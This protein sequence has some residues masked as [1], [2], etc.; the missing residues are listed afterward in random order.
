MGQPQAHRQSAHRRHRSDR[1]AGA[2]AD[3]QRARTAGRA[4]PRCACTPEP[5]PLFRRRDAAAR[6]RAPHRPGRARRDARALRSRALLDPPRSGAD[7]AP[8]ATAIRHGAH[9]R[10]G[11]D[12]E[13]RVLYVALTRPRHSLQIYAPLRYFHHPNGHD[14]ASGLGKLS[15][16]LHDEVQARCDVTAPTEPE[17]ALVAA[18]THA[19]R[20]GR[21]RPALALKT[22]SGAP[23]RTSPATSAELGRC[24]TG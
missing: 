5:P 13:R 3:D 15:R 1:C 21:R 10:D 20:H 8:T 22:R 23:E 12:E 19:T 9:E 24:R 2:G 17:P 14:D 4:A 7:L 16:F 6:P 18:E 11:L